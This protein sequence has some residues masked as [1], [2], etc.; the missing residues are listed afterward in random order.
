VTIDNNTGAA[1][2]ALSTSG[3]TWAGAAIT[4]VAPVVPPTQ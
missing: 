4:T 1:C 2:L 3:D